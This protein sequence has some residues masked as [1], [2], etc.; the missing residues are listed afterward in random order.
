M[1]NNI[2][3]IY[4]LHLQECKTIIDVIE[5]NNSIIDK[6][7][8]L[9]V[10][11]N[12]PINLDEMK[13]NDKLNQLFNEKIEDDSTEILTSLITIYKS[14]EHKQEHLISISNNKNI[15]INF[16]LLKTL[17]FHEYYYNKLLKADESLF[18]LE[19]IV[20]FLYLGF[21]QYL[22]SVLQ[23]KYN[24]ILDKDID[25]IIIDLQDI[26]R[27]IHKHKAYEVNKQYF[28]FFNDS[29]NQL[30]WLK[31]DLIEL[32]NIIYSELS[33][34]YL[35]NKF[36]KK[37]NN[38]FNIKIKKSEDI[39]KNLSESQQNAVDQLN[40]KINI[41]LGIPGSGKTHI[42]KEILKSNIYLNAL[43]LSKNKIIGSSFYSSYTSFTTKSFENNLKNDKVKNI[44]IDLSEK[45]E[46]KEDKLRLKINEIDKI[47]NDEEVSK[48]NEINEKLKKY[49]DEDIENIKFY[50][51]KNKEIYN[52]SKTLLT[53]E[54]K[55]A[56]LN[57]LKMLKL[58]IK[59]E[60]IISK[61]FK[62]FF[63]EKKIITI[64][65]KKQRTI[66][67]YIKIKTRLEESEIKDIFNK[68]KKIYLK[69]K[70]SDQESKDFLE[71]EIYSELNNINIDL[72]N[73][74]NE[75]E[76][77]FYIENRIHLEEENY[78]KRKKK[79]LMYLLSLELNKKGD[80]ELIKDIENIRVEIELTL[81]YFFPLIIIP[82]TEINN[83]FST[84]YNCLSIAIDEC[85]MLPSYYIYSIFSRTNQLY[86]VGDINQLNISSFFNLFDL[87]ERIKKIYNRKDNDNDS[88]LKY[89]LFFNNDFLV[90]NLFEI[91][92]ELTDNVSI[93][94]DNFRSKKEIVYSQ[95]RLN[96]SYEKY[97]YAY[98]RKNRI[99]I[100][101][102]KN[103]PENYLNLINIYKDK[104]DEYQTSEGTTLSPLLNYNENSTENPLNVKSKK[105]IKFLRDNEMVNKS[106][107]IT[108]L[109]KEESSKLDKII[110]KEN[111]TNNKIYSKSIDDIQGLEYDIVFFDTIISNNKELKILK[112]NINL[113]TV[114]ISRTKE[115]FVIITNNE[116]KSD[117]FIN[118]FLEVNDFKQF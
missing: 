93:L 3:K 80:I 85:F 82:S 83:Y 38:N 35:N 78:K 21:S 23:L 29:Y 20:K 7:K 30:K 37:I 62:F 26:I 15:Y 115:L 31:K 69:V 63:D 53:K 68:L 51:N 91:G 6:N 66:E 50:L 87:R 70:K 102:D 110:N 72:A 9:E 108:S 1:I 76:L 98:V 79:I 14:R 32:E 47:L 28:V 77:Y 99:K 94:T 90:K 40:C 92:L 13:F 41:L 57:I 73:E 104:K 22:Q 103:Q 52:A 18:N 24:N 64:P 10:C 8:I 89:N 88:F 84:Q 49:N 45:S 111:N 16:K 75:D 101:E 5:K 54:E 56:F 112:E 117:N 106:I 48:L 113:L 71:K 97:I 100:N 58:N 81:S 34:D 17:D 46:T 2:F 74:I 19:N 95:L 27:I 114:A 25:Q 59:E 55:E 116:T 39:K 86:L 43:S 44:Y 11:N 4:K 12:L 65:L 96:P 61:I 67:K 36:D 109:L 105:I 33:L 107:L 42:I 118:N 60:T